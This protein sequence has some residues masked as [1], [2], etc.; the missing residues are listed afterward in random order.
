MSTQ[1]LSKYISFSVLKIGA[2]GQRIGIKEG[3]PPAA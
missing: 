1:R 3:K 2:A